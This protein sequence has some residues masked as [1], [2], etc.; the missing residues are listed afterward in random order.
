MYFLEAIALISVTIF[1]ESQGAA[2]EKEKNPRSHDKDT[3]DTNGIV[4]HFPRLSEYLE[5]GYHIF[6][7][8]EIQ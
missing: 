7:V 4:F 1:A 8:I 3:N 6:T 5:K 2:N